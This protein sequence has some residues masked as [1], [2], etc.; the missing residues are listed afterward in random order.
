[1][2]ELKQGLHVPGV[3]ES[4]SR[5]QNRENWGLEEIVFWMGRV[6]SWGGRFA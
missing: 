1:M 3:G 6:G 5:N 2:E 4:G